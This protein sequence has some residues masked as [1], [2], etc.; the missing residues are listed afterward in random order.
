MSKYYAPKYEEEQ[1]HCPHC[2]VYSKQHWYD[3]YYQIY[4]NIKTNYRLCNCEHCDKKSL[5]KTNDK[6]MIDPITITH[7][8][9]HQEM[10]ID[11][12]SLY[13]EALSV[14]DLSPKAS[15]ALLRLAIQNLMPL[16]G[17]NI[18]KLDKDIAK[19]VSEGLPEEIQQALDYCRVIGNNAVHPNE[20]N[21]DDTPEMA[22]A[23]FEM[24]NFIVEEKIAK[25][26]RVKELFSRLPTGA[27]E[28]IEKRDKK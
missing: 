14:V 18:G 6:T 2:G 13:N 17:A 7:L 11:I 3:L 21:L 15:A 23:M 4:G 24:I 5:W 22:H 19:L 16:I 28:A 1:F 26:K 12:K 20:L 8:P 27:I 9:A 25:P 10:P